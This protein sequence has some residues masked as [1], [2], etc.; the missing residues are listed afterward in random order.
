MNIPNTLNTPNTLT[1][2][3]LNDNIEIHKP[4]IGIPTSKLK[5]DLIIMYTWDINGYYDNRVCGHMYEVI[6]YFW[7]LKDYFN[8]KIIFPEEYNLEKVVAK[9]DFN[10]DEIQE[11]RNAC[12]P[13][14]KTGI[15]RTR[16]GKGLILVVDGNLGNFKGFLYGIPV[17]FSCGKL[18]L[19]PKEKDQNWYLL[20]DNRICDTNE[21]VGYEVNPATRKYNYTKK[22]LFDRIPIILR[23]TKFE[24]LNPLTGLLYLT[25][26]CKYLNEEQIIETVKK[27]SEIGPKYGTSLSNRFMKYVIVT[28]Y[29]ININN[30]LAYT[31]PKISIEIIDIMGNP[32]DIFKLDFSH[33]IYTNVKREW[34]CSNRLIAECQHNKRSVI[35]DINYY[36]NALQTRMRDSF[37]H[38]IYNNLNL[39]KDDSII[40]ILYDIHSN[41]IGD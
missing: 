15:V 5:P 26:N 24:N 27:F 39:T 37:P 29:E 34:D 16:K 38:T 40:D 2:L 20:H 3:D 21:F 14:P 30:I 18:G 13:R 8:T 7:L 11:I 31:D 17:Q 22:I 12:I 4:L 33:Y 1:P 28:D 41:Y 32:I 6:E 10:E 23:N 36:D 9:Y 35:I 19:V 25:S